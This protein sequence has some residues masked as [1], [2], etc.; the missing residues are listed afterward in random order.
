[1]LEHEKA[2]LARHDCANCRRPIFSGIDARQTGSTIE[3]LQ[4][5]GIYK[6]GHNGPIPQLAV[7]PIVIVV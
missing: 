6:L 7:A 3:P 4:P 5:S 2:I 1:M